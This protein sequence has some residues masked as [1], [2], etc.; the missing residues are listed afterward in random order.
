M[1]CAASREFKV[2][3]VQQLT[4]SRSSA[5]IG[6]AAGPW[7]SRCSCG[8]RGLSK[9]HI[10]ALPFVFIGNGTGRKYVPKEQEMPIGDVEYAAGG[11]V[12]LGLTAGSEISSRETPRNNFICERCQQEARVL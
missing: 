8:P 11:S 1:L 12:V 4:N 3:L 9:D 5:C 7:W 10:S 6:R 2:H